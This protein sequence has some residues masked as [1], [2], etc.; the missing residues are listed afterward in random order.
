[1]RP[2][3]LPAGKHMA[4]EV[5][6]WHSHTMPSS[7]PKQARFMAAVAHGWQPGQVKAPPVRVAKEF[8]QADV[9]SH[10]LRGKMPPPPH[11]ASGGE[12]SGPFAPGLAYGGE[13]AVDGVDGLGMAGYSRGG[14]VG[15]LTGPRDR[16]P[17]GSGSMDMSPP[18][19][20]DELGEHHFAHGGPVDDPRHD[21][22]P[23]MLSPGE[24]VLPR[25]VTQAPG[26]PEAAKGFVAG[27][28]SRALRAHAGHRM[29]DGGEVPFDPETLSRGMDAALEAVPPDTIIK[30]KAAAKKVAKPTKMAEGGEVD[31]PDVHAWANTKGIKE[32]SRTPM[33]DVDVTVGEP[34]IL[35]EISME[36][37]TIRTAPKIEMEGEPT[38]RKVSE[39]PRA[40]RELAPSTPQESAVALAEKLRAGRGGGA[41][42]PLTDTE[43]KALMQYLNANGPGKIHGFLATL[44]FRR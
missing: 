14:E 23:A 30:A 31:D 36:G 10:I 38:I 11:M 13:A 26:A 28:R 42:T 21:T 33:P 25:S 27:L 22:V 3:I 17:Q 15:G 39:V 40:R 20:A 29:A 7:S 32:L 37:P 8:N 1:M 18:Y 43:Q 44:G 6:Q 4:P 19:Y 16:A 41:E 12:V 5:A 9:R 35:P 2:P 34:Q 24:V